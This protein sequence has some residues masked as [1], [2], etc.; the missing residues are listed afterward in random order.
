MGA[1]RCQVHEDTGPVQ[2]RQ[3]L[4]S[5]YLVNRCF[6]DNDLVSFS[7][8]ETVMTVVSKARKRS[9]RVDEGHFE[10]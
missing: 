8:C 5:K 2:R 9:A 6:H 3:G 10:S 1:N 4:D 7:G